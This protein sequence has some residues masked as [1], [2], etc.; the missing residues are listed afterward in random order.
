MELVESTRKMSKPALGVKTGVDIVATLVAGQSVA[1]GGGVETEI[2]VAHKTDDYTS[3]KPSPEPKGKNRVG[4]IKMLHL[5]I[6]QVT[7]YKCVTQPNEVGRTTQVE[8]PA[9]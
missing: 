7:G 1:V 3:A 4:D 2:L 8:G 5:G 6:D 9:H